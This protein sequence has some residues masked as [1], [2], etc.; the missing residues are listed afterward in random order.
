ME[1]YVYS[2]YLKQT[3]IASK[4]SG[5]SGEIFSRSKLRRINKDRD[6]NPISSP[7]GLAY[8]A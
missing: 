1:E 8:Q 2:F 5:V 6:H 3:A 7:L 4:V